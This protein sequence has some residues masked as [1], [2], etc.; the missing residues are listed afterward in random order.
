M[1]WKVNWGY[2]AVSLAVG[3]KEKVRRRRILRVLASSGCIGKGGNRLQ[4]KELL[5][6]LSESAGVAGFEHGLHSSLRA[7]WEPL[8]HEMSTDVLGNFVAKRRG[9]GEEPR[10]SVMLA[11]HMDEVGMMVTKI[12]ERGYIRFTQ[13]GGIDPRILP[14]M[15]VTVHGRRQLA[16]IIGTKPPHLLSAG[17][18]DKAPKMEELFIDVGLAQ[19]RLVDVVEIGDVI[20]FQR[21]VTELANDFLA[22]KSF[23]DRAGVAVIHSCLQ[24]LEKLCITADVYA[25]ATVQE[26]IG[27]KGATVSTY[28]LEPD[29]GIAIDVCHGDGPG[30]P[31]DLVSELG[32]GP[33]ITMGPNIA[34]R[35]YELLEQAAK[36]AGIEVQVD[37]APAQT[38]TDAWAMQI[39][40]HG[41]PTGLVSV[42]LRYMHTSVETLHLDDVEKAGKL[43]AFFI[44]AVNRG[45]VEGLVW[46]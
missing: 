46:S 34:P 38:G 29:I 31:E 16:G 43:L 15:E 20:T 8:V 18:E 37:V 23:D 11:A 2:R 7:A 45:F 5:K 21:D 27:L 19:E 12:D 26:E 30:Q 28:G 35:V 13:V 40:R 6:N 32:K 22:G 25:V 44:A 3:E 42:P 17:E 39:S 33:V 41:V 24:W 1:S 10:P 14:G 4:V 9:V 36:D